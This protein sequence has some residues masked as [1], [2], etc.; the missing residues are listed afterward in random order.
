MAQTER[1]VKTAHAILWHLNGACKKSEGWFFQ[2]DGYQFGLL[3]CYL[4]VQALKN[5]GKEFPLFLPLL[6]HFW[7]VKSQLE[8]GTFCSQ[9][10][11]F[12]SNLEQGLFF[13]FLD[14]ITVIRLHILNY[15]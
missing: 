5:R 15:C 1:P 7:H 14:C 13:F 4:S 10:P 6:L 12:T 9:N 2:S 11:C 8:P 3:Q